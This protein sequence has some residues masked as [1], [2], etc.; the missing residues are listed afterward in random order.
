MI[1]QGKNLWGNV[2][3][4]DGMYHVSLSFVCI[5]EI[6]LSSVTDLYILLFLT[7]LRNPT[8]PR[9][10]SGHFGFYFAVSGEHDLSSLSDVI[11]QV[12]VEQG[13]FKS[14]NVT[15]FTA[16]EIR[17]YFGVSFLYHFWF[18]RIEDDFVCKG[19]DESRK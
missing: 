19:K 1:G 5:I 3:I 16:E 9:P 12:L 13:R 4:H 2:S 17:K 14:E 10:G 15:S 11:S 6:C 7:I 8:P 18:E